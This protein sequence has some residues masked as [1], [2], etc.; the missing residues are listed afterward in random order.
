MTTKEED[1]L[2]GDWELVAT[3]RKIANINVPKTSDLPFN[4]KSPPKLSDSIRNSI[5]VL[6]RIRS[7]SEESSKIDRVD[8]VIQYTPLTLS[9]FIPESSPLSAIRSWNVNPLEV[10]K[11]KVVLIHNAEVES[12][13]PTLR[14]KLGLKSVIVNVAGTSQY[15]EADG[16]DVLGLNIPSL[17]DFANGG[18]FDSTYVDENVRISRGTVGFL[19]ELRVFVREGS[20]LES[21]AKTQAEEVVEEAPTDVVEE[22]KQE[23]ESSVEEEVEPLIEEETSEEVKD[24]AKVEEVISD[25]ERAEDNGE[26]LVTDDTVEPIEKQEDV[27]MTVSSNDGDDEALKRKSLEA[28][29]SKKLKSKLKKAGLSTDGRKSDLIQRLMDIE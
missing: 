28:M 2:L 13:E 11:S 7:T 12:V 15:L 6:Q 23:E 26:P 10:S 25:E 3:S 22:E 17:G 27:D 14:T 16:A 8:H 1:L 19:D 21:L 18:S 24:S 29:T 20:D 5:T 4:I 9:D